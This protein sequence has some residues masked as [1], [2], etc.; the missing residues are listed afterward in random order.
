M[1]E[2][3][4][5]DFNHLRKELENIKST[6]GKS[7]YSHIKDVFEHLILHSPS[8]ALERFEEISYLIKQGRDPAEF[9]NCEDVRNYRD[10][11]KNQEDYVGKMAEHF[12]QPEPDE[13]GNIPL[14]DPLA[15]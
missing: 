5:V 15:T 4:D 11:A 1:R 8:L 2:L 12:V 14:A 7:L 3:K 9:L 13:E 6:A 10:L